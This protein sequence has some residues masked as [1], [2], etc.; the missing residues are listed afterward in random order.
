MYS[1][2][3][4]RRVWW[5]RASVPNVPNFNEH[6]DGA[7]AGGVRDEQERRGPEVQGSAPYSD[8][9]HSFGGGS[10]GGKPHRR[11]A[12]TEIRPNV[13]GG[14]AWGGP[15]CGLWGA[16]EAS[17]KWPSGCALK[18]CQEFVWLVGEGGAAY[19]W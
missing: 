2:D 13:T 5:R 17:Q 7:L 14:R 1:Q 19:G 8:H 15:G 10:G 9:P 4:N 11:S 18:N 3:Q 16:G 12:A 6:F